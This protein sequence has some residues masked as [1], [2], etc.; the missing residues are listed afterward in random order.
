MVSKR[1]RRSEQTKENALTPAALLKPGAVA[2]GAGLV[3]AVVWVG[4]SWVTQGDA[5][6]MAI[7]V[8]A[9][10]GLAVRATAKTIRGA[11]PGALAA[12]VAVATAVVG[13][14]LVSLLVSGP[15]SG[16]SDIVISDYIM[17]HSLALDVVND[18]MAKNQKVVWPAGV[19][20]KSASSPSDFPKD[21]WEEAQRNFSA[22]S[23]AEKSA[24][25]RKE[26]AKL[27]EFLQPF[28]AEV[29]KAE[30]KSRISFGWED[31]LF[32]AL[33]AAAAFGLGS[34]L[35]FRRAEEEE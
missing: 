28:Q 16:G 1:S 18:R 11:V 22:L 3:G 10:S 23:G 2:L 20:L 32:V 21:I 29:K 25:R 6:W 33:G 4:L 30:T 12:G 26:E 27:R 8:G 24:L 15:N 34:R 7:V 19:T 17:T 14:I 5:G 31:M 35:S 13:K 9:L